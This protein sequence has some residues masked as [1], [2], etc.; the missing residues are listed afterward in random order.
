MQVL[1]VS[2]S[3]KEVYSPF[4]QL[5]CLNGVEDAVQSRKNTSKTA[6]ER[7]KPTAYGMG[8]L[9]LDFFEHFHRLLGRTTS[10]V[11][12]NKNPF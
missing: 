11:L 6:Q 10:C 1:Q 12:E 5:C 4:L 3:R 7:S 2:K 8:Q 9:T